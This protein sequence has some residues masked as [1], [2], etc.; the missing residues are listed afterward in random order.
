MTI[1]DLHIEY[2][3]PLF[4]ATGG[5]GQIMEMRADQ[6]GV[7]F[8]VMDHHGHILTIPF[9]WVISIWAMGPSVSLGFKGEA[10]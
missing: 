5:G 10:A 4:P 1:Q 8:A 2:E 9:R 3:D 6:E 7:E